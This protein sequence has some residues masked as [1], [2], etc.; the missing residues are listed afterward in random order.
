MPPLKKTRT[1]EN[2]ATGPSQPK[3]KLSSK[4]RYNFIA[5]PLP[6]QKFIRQASTP[7]TSAVPISTPSN[8]SSEGLHKEV[9][10]LHG[11]IASLKM[12]VESL[13]QVVEAV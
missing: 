6:S 12:M 11:K 9:E 7:S 8:H 1:E 5:V 10:D 13:R 3:S 2:T 4:G